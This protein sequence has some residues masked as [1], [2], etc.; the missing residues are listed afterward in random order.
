MCGCQTLAA[1]QSY[2][3]DDATPSIPPGGSLDTWRAAEAILRDTCSYGTDHMN[4]ASFEAAGHVLPR[5]WR[6]ERDG[7]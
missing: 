2:S 4:Y 6:F 7:P 1:L 3:G 5:E